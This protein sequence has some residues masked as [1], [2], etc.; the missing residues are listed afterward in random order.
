MTDACSAIP[1]WGVIPAAGQS[2]RFAKGTGT[3]PAML[4]QLALLD[5]RSMLAVVLDVVDASALVGA[6]VV[7]NPQVAA[8]IEAE[9]PAGPRRRYIINA[10]PDSEMIESIQIGLEAVCEWQGPSAPMPASWGVMICPG[11]QPGMTTAVLD[12]CVQAF[13]ENPSR[14]IIAV[15]QGR[16]G[17]PLIVPRDLAEQVAA[18]P[19]TARLSDLHQYYPD[20]ALTVETDEPG[21]LVDIDR[22]EDL[23][24]WRSSLK[25]K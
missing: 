2:R 12:R 18:W 1:V 21:V 6:A 5:G 15:H 8:S 17:H 16:R 4:K 25:N 14:I 13:R 11:D 20:R 7:V 24:A 9:R 23:E 3:N 10:R 22:P 19:P